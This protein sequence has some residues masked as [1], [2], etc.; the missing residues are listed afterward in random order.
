MNSASSLWKACVMLS[1]LQAAHASEQGGARR[2]ARQIL[3]DS[4]VAGGVIVHLGCGGGEVTSALHASDSFL[5]QG[6]DASEHSVEAARKHIQ[7]LGL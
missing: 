5:V 3:K 2:L 6:L 4:G 1:I 7:S